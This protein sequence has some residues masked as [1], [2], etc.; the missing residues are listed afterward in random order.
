MLF[1]VCRLGHALMG[2]VSELHILLLLL[3]LCVCCVQLLAAMRSVINNPSEHTTSA[4]ADHVLELC[5]PLCNTATVLCRLNHELIEGNNN[6]NTNTHASTDSE[7][8]GNGVLPTLWAFAWRVHQLCAS[9]LRVCDNE[10][11]SE[12]ETT[13]GTESTQKVGHSVQIAPCVACC[14]VE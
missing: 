11:Q 4:S 7:D 12:T 6:T 9:Q 2:F 3:I 5:L 13:S 10:S 8:N 14:V 1:G